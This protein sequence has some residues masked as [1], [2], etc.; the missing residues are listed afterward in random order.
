MVGSD[1]MCGSD[2]PCVVTHTWGTCAVGVVG[3]FFWVLGGQVVVRGGR[4]EQ[5]Q[6]PDITGFLRNW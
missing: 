3:V 1:H 5:L 4:A 6:N 2:Y